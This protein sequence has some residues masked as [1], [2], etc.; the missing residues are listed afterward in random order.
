MSYLPSCLM[1]LLT[2]TRSF[3]AIYL[4]TMLKALGIPTSKKILVHPHWTVDRKKMSK[5]VGNVVD[6]FQVMD[7]YGVDVVRFYLARVGG[8]YAGD[9]GMS[10]AFSTLELSAHRALLDWSEVQLNKFEGE[11]RN[12]LGNLFSRTHSKAVM[13]RLPDY[14]TV[15][16]S[17]LR[18]IAEDGPLCQWAFDVMNGLENLGALVSE[19]LAK[20]DLKTAL[21]RIVLQLNMVCRRR[22]AF[23]SV[24]H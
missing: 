10:A 17:T 7:E 23:C 24:P 20:L 3:H 16:G 13:G 15:R 14:Y 9:H 6:P 19:D 18:T 5:S 11:L 2:R 12:Q 4:P 21:D 8:S 1:V 22:N